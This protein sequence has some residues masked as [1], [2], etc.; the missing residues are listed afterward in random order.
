MPDASQP[1]PDAVSALRDDERRRTRAFLLVSAPLAVLGALAAPLLG[2]TTWTCVAF[3]MGVVLMLVVYGWLWRHLGADRVHSPRRALVA[4]T[5][6]NLSGVAAALH[7]GVFSP[8]SMCLMLPIAYFGLSESLGAASAS[9]AVTGLALAVPR[10]LIGVGLLVGTPGHMSPEQVRALPVSARSDVF[11]LA[12]VAYRALTGRPPFSAP[13][14]HAVLLK[15]AQEMPP[16]PGAIVSLPPAVDAVF[17]WALC[18]DPARRAPSTLAFALALAA[19]M[20]G[21]VVPEAEA[22]APAVL[23]STP[24]SR[25]GRAAVFGRPAR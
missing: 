22:A 18:K 21:R 16:R 10:V 20:E 13:S 3:I 14:A 19:A 24:W 2:G 17:A 6:A 25:P 15:V 12:T 7:H 8:A 4:V 9:A 5:A 1:R 23:A 11:A